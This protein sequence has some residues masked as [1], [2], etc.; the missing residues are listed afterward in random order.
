M[1]KKYSVI[2]NWNVAGN[3]H[4]ELRQIL[5][6]VFANTR[7]ENVPTYAVRFV[8]PCI[9]DDTRIQVAVSGTG[10]YDHDPS[11]SF[12]VGLPFRSS[13]KKE[14][15]ENSGLLASEAYKEME[16]NHTGF[17]LVGEKDPK[18]FLWAP[19]LLDTLEQRAKLENQ[20]DVE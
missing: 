20:D 19:N 9:E 16:R 12:E 18:L 7:V 11:A 8:T 13:L 14:A 5:D 15:L 17:L 4:D 1:S 6:E 2:D 3:D 10:S